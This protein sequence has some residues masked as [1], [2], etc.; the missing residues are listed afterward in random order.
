MRGSLGACCGFALAL[1][2]SK[3]GIGLLWRPLDEES[4]ELPYL[5]GVRLFVCGVAGHAPE[6]ILGVPPSIIAAL[7]YVLCLSFSSNLRKPADVVCN[8]C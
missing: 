5:G 1:K 4:P 2:E 3:P 8:Q 7:L 6:R